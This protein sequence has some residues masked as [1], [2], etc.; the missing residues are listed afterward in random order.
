MPKEWGLPV[1]DMNQIRSCSHSNY[2]LATYDSGNTQSNQVVVATNVDANGYPHGLNIDSLPLAPVVPKEW[3]LPV[4]DMNQIRS[5]SYASQAPV[6]YDYADAQFNQTATLA[7]VSS[8]AAV[9]SYPYGLNLHELAVAPVVP[10]EWGLP[11]VDMNQI[12]SL[13]HA[14]QASSYASHAASHAG[15]ASS[16]TGHAGANPY[17]IDNFAYQY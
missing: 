9:N 7:N 12:R 1:I 10:K 17:I 2:D 14:S 8:T 16:H 15:H 11:V 13:S 4:V 6:T 5:R 3:G